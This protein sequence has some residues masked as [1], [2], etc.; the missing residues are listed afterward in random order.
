MTAKSKYDDEVLFV[1]KLHQVFGQP[2]GTLD[3]SKYKN[4]DKAELKVIINNF[5]IDYDNLD[6]YPE[7]DDEELLDTIEKNIKNKVTGHIYLKDMYLFKS[8]NF[9][10]YLHRKSQLNAVR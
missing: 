4:A 1:Q 9:D 2:D 10:D 7:L 8:K 6:M 3:L 5:D